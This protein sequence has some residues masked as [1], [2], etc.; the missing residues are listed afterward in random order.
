MKKN[1]LAEFELFSLAFQRSAFPC[2]YS[3]NRERESNSNNNNH[4]YNHN[5]NLITIRIGGK[6]LFCRS[7][8][9]HYSKMSFTRF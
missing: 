6:Q 7:I 2:L 4:N 1:S 3:H 8:T 9:L 5:R